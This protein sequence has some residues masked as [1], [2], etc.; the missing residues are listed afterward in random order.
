M[1][2]YFPVGCLT[3]GYVSDISK[4][5]HTW[6]ETHFISFQELF[7]K[8]RCVPQNIDGTRLLYT[9]IK[10][11]T[12]NVCENEWALRVVSLTQ[13]RGRWEINPFSYIG[14]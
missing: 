12:Y 6:L 10:Y 7:D 1:L 3:N 13:Y 2:R 4:F 8:E 9:L 11:L 14:N 5:T